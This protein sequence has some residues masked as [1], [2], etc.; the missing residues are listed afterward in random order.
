M[1]KVLL[2]VGISL[3]LLCGVFLF[4]YSH[5]QDKPQDKPLYQGP[6]PQGYDE[7]YFRQTGITKPLEKG[8]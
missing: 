2:I 6:V 5:S 7:Q 1:N 8:D 3:V 4:V